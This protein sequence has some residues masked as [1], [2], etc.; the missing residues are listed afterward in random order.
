MDNTAYIALSR[1]NALRRQLDVV[2]NNVANVNTVGFKQQRMLF[3]E[4][5]QRPGMH[6]KA[7]YVQDRAVVRDLTAGGF[8]STSNPMDMAI[9]GNG[10]FVVDTVNGP[11]YTRNGSFRLD[12]ERRIVNGEGLPLLSEGGQP[13]TLPQEIT[14]F[15]VRGDRTIVTEQGELAKVNVVAFKKEQLMTEVGNGLYVSDEKPDA[16][17]VETKLAQGMLEQSNVK[18]VLEMTNMIEIMRQYQTA[19]K[20]MEG[21]HERVRNVISRIGRVA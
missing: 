14:N 18:P 11:R 9:H 16:A 4:F 6:E 8:T 1:Q 17:P 13:I 5:L 2:A 12:T 10:Y 19:Q 3:N 20:M 21:E 15:E 7:S